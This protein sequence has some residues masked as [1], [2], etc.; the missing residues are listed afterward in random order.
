MAAQEPVILGIFH[1]RVVSV[2]E[3]NATTIEVI[4]TA[5]AS[6][7]QPVNDGV[8]ISCGDTTDLKEAVEATLNVAG[9][10][11]CCGGHA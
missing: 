5:R 8:R 1:L 10:E 2:T 3:V 6:N 11:M 9:K 4:S 7:I